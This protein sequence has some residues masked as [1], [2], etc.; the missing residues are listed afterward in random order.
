[1]YAPEHRGRQ[2]IRPCLAAIDEALSGALTRTERARLCTC[3]TPAKSRSLLS[4]LA[5]SPCRALTRSVSTHM[6]FLDHKQPPG[7]VGSFDADGAGD[8]DQP[9]CFGWRPRASVPYPFN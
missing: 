5:R 6:T 1:M 7:S 9:Y 3:A 8:N 2:S 4:E